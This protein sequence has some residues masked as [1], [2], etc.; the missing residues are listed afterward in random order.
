M[1]E[2]VFENCKDWICSRCR[3][4]IF[5]RTFEHD[6]WSNNFKTEERLLNDQMTYLLA[7]VCIRELHTFQT[8]TMSAK[9][10]KKIA[11]FNFINVSSFYIKQGRDKFQTDFLK[12]LQFC[13]SKLAR[14]TSHGFCVAPSFEENVPRLA[15][16]RSIFLTPGLGSISYVRLAR[17]GFKYEGRQP[18]VR[19][20]DCGQEI[21]IFRFVR[22][23]NCV[24]DPGTTEFHANG[25]SFISTG[26]ESSVSGESGETAPGASSSLTSVSTTGSRVLQIESPVPQ[27]NSNTKLH[28]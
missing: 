16:F 27:G 14:F 13:Q 24:S 25:C 2:V 4:F 20:V 19:C 17:A 10:A 8:L 5:S 23:E 26:L 22:D 7:H 11:Q 28:R 15:S 12:P 18:Y 21:S 6:F 3:D 1:A 9:I